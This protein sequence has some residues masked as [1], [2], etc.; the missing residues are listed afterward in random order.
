[1]AADTPETEIEPVSSPPADGGVEPSAP[2]QDE[3][4]LTLREEIEAAAREVR[5]ETDK[6]ADERPRDATG[7]FLPKADAPA[8]NQVS[9][10]SDA[11]ASAPSSPAATSGTPAAPS[12]APA[13]PPP[14]WD[15]E[16]KALYPKLPP[17]IQA[18]VS[19]REE[20][21][22]RGFAQYA[23]AKQELERVIAP[24]RQYYSGDGVSD[25]QAID[26]IWK[27]FEALKN[28]PN[29]ALPALAQMF[30]ATISSGAPA[31]SPQVNPE[32]AV[33]RA[34][35]Q[36]LEGQ[37]GQVAGTFE[38]QQT[39]ARRAEIAEFAKDKPHFEKV[40]VTMGR[41]MSAGVAQGLTDAYQQAVRITPEVS[42][43][44]AADE[45]AAA[46]KVAAEAA[47][48][49]RP[50]SQRRAAVSVRGGSPNGSAGA[51]VPAGSLREE[52]QRQFAEARGG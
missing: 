16:A 26:N 33:L 18:A 20:E 44:L 2:S 45:K 41:L 11:P 36:R 37:V 24:R 51:A 49:S 9:R 34:H 6:P 14:G 30:G 47:L 35:I 43:A 27:W 48:R 29:E 38:Q 25:T 31:D 8:P 40:R 7:R 46:D 28:S 50:G 23:Q 1:V 4:P 39:A 21:V 52:L 5:G 22:S 3:A 19:R 42:A 15:A 32:V 13:G 10:A 12:T 17:A